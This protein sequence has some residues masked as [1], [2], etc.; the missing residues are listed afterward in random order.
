M[1]WNNYKS[2]NL[3]TCCGKREASYLLKGGDK[4]ETTLQCWLRLEIGASDLFSPLCQR[5]LSMAQG[6]DLCITQGIVQ[7]PPPQVLCSLAAP[8]SFITKTLHSPMRSWSLPAASLYDGWWFLNPSCFHER[9]A[10]RRFSA[11][12]GTGLIY[13]PLGSQHTSILC[14]YA[15]LS[16]CRHALHRWEEVSGHRAP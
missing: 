2:F 15:R 9:Q 11:H 1:K 3:S 10:D 5:A 13:H 12:V 7:F 6:R 8:W 4:M 16:Q 14:R